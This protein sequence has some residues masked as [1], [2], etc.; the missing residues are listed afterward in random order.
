MYISLGWPE[1]D[2][3]QDTDYF[4][5][6]TKPHDAVEEQ[7]D[8][9]S[10]VNCVFRSK[11]VWNGCDSLKHP[12]RAIREPQTLIAVPVMFVGSAENEMCCSFISSFIFG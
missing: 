5:V 9:T 11:D 12:A 3:H 2:A 8:A 6:D 1:K 4:A 10:D 7:F